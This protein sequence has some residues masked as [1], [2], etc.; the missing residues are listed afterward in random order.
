MWACRYCTFQN[1]A[2]ANLCGA[3]GSEN[4]KNR[5]RS[6]GFLSKFP[7]ISFN[8]AVNLIDNAIDV[9]RD[10]ATSSSSSSHQNGI[11]AQVLQDWICPR[12]Q[13][14]NDPETSYCGRCNFHRSN[15]IRSNNWIC[16]KCNLQQPVAPVNFI[17]PLCKKKAPKII[18]QSAS[19]PLLTSPRS[20]PLLYEVPV[21]EN[22]ND[23][24][25]IYENV[26]K[27]CKDHRQP[28]I[29][30]SFPH[31]SRSIGNFRSLEKSHI[32]I[33]WLRPSEIY[34]KDGRICPWKVFNNPKP[35]D[36]EQ[37]LLGNCW[38]LSGLAVIAE[39]PEIL[40]KI[41]LTK[42]YNVHGVYKIR[43]CVD[44]LFRTVL[45][46]DFFPCHKKSRSMIFAVGRNNQLWPS[47]MEKALAKIYG[48]YGNLKAGRAVEGLATLTGSPCEH[49]DLEVDMTMSPNEAK[50][51]L[52]MIWARLL[53]AKDANFLMG[54]SCGAGRRIVK[55]EKHSRVGLMTRHAYSILDVR[56]Y[57]P[58]RLLR[59]RNPW[60][61][62]T[63]KGEWSLGWPGWDS[64]NKLELNY[65]QTRKDTGTFWMPFERF[66][67]YFD[68]VEVAHMNVG[69][70][71]QR[72]PIELNWEQCPILRITVIE[73]TE[74]C[75][76]LFQRNA[77]TALDQVD[78]V[79]LVHREDQSNKQPGE[80]IIRSNRR[81]LPSVRTEDKFFEPGH[82]I[83]TA[84]S[85]QHFVE[86]KTV[87]ATLVMHSA[88]YVEAKFETTTPDIQRQSLV[89]MALAEGTPIEYLPNVRLYQ[90]SN[91]FSGL[92][93]M[94]DNLQESYCVQVKA[95]CSSSQNVLSSRAD[96]TVADCIPPLH[97]QILLILT[98]CEP[99]QSFIVQHQLNQRLTKHAK[100]GDFS[101][102]SFDAQNEPA[103]IRPS[104]IALHGP[105]PLYL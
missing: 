46:D 71:A 81:C 94:I 90:I 26:V 51:A 61:V 14:N 32:D 88:R 45:V 43:L 85:L 89:Q 102:R 6:N 76:T 58:H 40:E 48:N 54:C 101:F 12:C 7:S 20:D 21:I 63:W 95:D 68:S 83:C 44:G 98:H 73:P 18:V 66:T 11:I 79:L 64:S 36:I 77:R 75:F 16:Q 86:G 59:I 93:L 60:G 80:L 15:D 67:Q 57:G 87:P 55:E 65:E 38:L 1:A 28:F 74:I 23:V 82:Y 13:L 3:C 25:K 70:T 29:D 84:M 39:R 22:S 96:L 105:R 104:T 2:G 50:Q 10:V 17:C 19:S 5:G 49:I 47:L 41:V 35:T 42:S 52:E 34:T 99:S 103:F 62:G 4:P 8:G 92:L 24:D 53:S 9:F 100:L 30:D 27:F 33:V 78:I 97:R 31:S 69:W 91:N 37:G 72:F 56:Q